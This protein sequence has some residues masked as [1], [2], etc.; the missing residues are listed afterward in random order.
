MLIDCGLGFAT[1]GGRNVQHG[2][3]HLRSPSHNFLSVVTARRTPNTLG[4]PN[5]RRVPVRGSLS[6]RLNTWPACNRFLSEYLGAVALRA[7]GSA[8]CRTF[9]SRAGSADAE[10]SPCQEI[11]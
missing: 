10:L 11:R 4:P 2:F 7:P 1:L 8:A 6:G 9:H 5:S 3:A